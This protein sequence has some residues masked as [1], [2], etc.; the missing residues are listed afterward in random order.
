MKTSKIL[1]VVFT[2]LLTMSA[3]TAMANII[4]TPPEFDGTW[5]VVCNYG[6]GF[7]VYDPVA[8]GMMFVGGEN[9]PLQFAITTE[10]YPVF[11]PVYVLAA[12]S[13]YFAS[14]DQILNAGDSFLGQDREVKISFAI[15]GTDTPF[16]VYDGGTYQ[17][18]QLIVNGRET[19]LITVKCATPNPVPVPGAVWLLGSGLVGIVSLRRKG[20]QQ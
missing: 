16:T 20:N 13:G 8:D 6:L 12:A 19:G 5:T 3:Q 15:S 1:T 18:L 4:T 2:C 11:T 14:Y 9:D 17:G 10:T 7:S